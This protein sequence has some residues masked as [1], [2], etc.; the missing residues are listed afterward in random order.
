VLVLGSQEGRYVYVGVSEL[1]IEGML[2]VLVLVRVLGVLVLDA[3]EV[4]APLVADT[5]L[6]VGLNVGGCVVLLLLLVLLIIV[7]AGE[8]VAFSCIRRES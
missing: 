5:V 6:L 8:V 7:D 2:L 4:G 1:I 3:L